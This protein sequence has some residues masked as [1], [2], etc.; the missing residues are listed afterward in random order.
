MR[1]GA[2]LGDEYVQYSRHAPRTVT[3]LAYMWHR[4]ID[5]RKKEYRSHRVNTF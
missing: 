4:R 2:R 3:L 1:G 5:R